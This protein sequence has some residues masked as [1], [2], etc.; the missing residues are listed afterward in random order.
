MTAI[1]IASWA[2]AAITVSLAIFVIG[3]TAMSLA[4][5]REGRKKRKHHH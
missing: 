2:F 3:F 5:M 4:A 1:E